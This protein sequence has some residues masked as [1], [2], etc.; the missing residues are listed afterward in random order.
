MTHFNK[1]FTISPDLA[2][3]VERIWLNESDFEN[4]KLLAIENSAYFKFALQIQKDPLI[5]PK[6]YTALR[7]LTGPGDEYYDDYKGSYSFTFKLDVLKNGHLSNYLYSIY[8][9]RSYIEFY[10]RQIVPKTNPQETEIMHQPNNELFS[11]DDICHFCRYFSGYLLGYIKEAQNTPEP[12][13]KGSDSNCLLFGFYNGEYFCTQYDS[14]EEYKKKK[15]A[16]KREL[17]N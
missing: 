9:Y 12:F 10:L 17:Q 4:K 16:L 15:S 3:T 7:C 1:T 6:L 11:D 2:V 13:V 5:L 8:N 14:S